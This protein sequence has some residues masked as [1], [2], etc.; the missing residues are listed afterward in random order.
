ML[1]VVCKQ[2]TAYEMR[3]SDWSSYV[4][5]SDLIG[6]LFAA[7]R[8]AVVAAGGWRFGGGD[9]PTGSLTLDAQ[10]DGSVRGE[11][12]FVPYV[13]EGARLALDPVRFFGAADGAMRFVTRAGL[14][15]PRA[16]GRVERL[17]VPV[18]LGQG[19]GRGRG[20]RVV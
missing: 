12:R 8:P 20:G 1:C 18:A 3:M 10:A 9:L 14:S 6:W 11:A 19:A 2:K 7:S 15:G 5:S 16:A 17:T 13:A 4:C